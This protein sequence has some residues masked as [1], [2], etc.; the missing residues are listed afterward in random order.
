MAG[1]NQR[2]TRSSQPIRDRAPFGGGWNGDNFDVPGTLTAVTFDQAAVCL[3]RI[4]SADF[5]IARSIACIQHNPT[6][7]DGVTVTIADGGK[8]M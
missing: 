5:A 7:N 1:E 6:I 3:N 8:L 2:V 4:I